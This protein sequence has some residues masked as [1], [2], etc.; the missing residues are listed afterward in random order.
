MTKSD[1]T[2]RQ[3]DQNFLHL[4]LIYTCSI[5]VSNRCEV[6]VAR[7][8]VI[9]LSAIADSNSSVRDSVTVRKLGN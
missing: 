4:C 5:C 1:V 6:V 9:G 3:F 7:L 8:A 2:L